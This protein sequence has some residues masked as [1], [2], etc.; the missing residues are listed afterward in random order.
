M[1]IFLSSKRAALRL[2]RLINPMAWVWATV[3]AAAII[4]AALFW[5][6]AR[7]RR[8][9][10]HFTREQVIVRQARQDLS[11]GYLHVTLAGR[12]GSPFDRGQGLAL[13]GQA[14][15]GL[16]R[17]LGLKHEFGDADEASHSQLALFRRAVED[18]RA[19][20]IGR[21]DVSAP[22]PASE[23]G[24]RIAFFELEQKANAVDVLIQQ[25]LSRMMRGY[26]RFHATVLW[27]SAV[28]LFFICLAVY[29]GDRARKLAEK[30]LRTNEEIY[31]LIVTN[32]SEAILFTNPDGSVYSVNPAACR[33]FGRSEEE[34]RRVGRAGIVDAADPRL[35]AALEER[36]RTGSFDGE[37]NMLRSDG[38]KFQAE[39]STAIFRDS[40]GSERTSMIIRDITE[41]KRADEAI[42]AS[43][44]EIHHRVKNNM[45]VI[46]SLFNLQAAHITNEECRSILKEGQ[47]RIRSMSLVHEKLYQSRDLS[48]IDFGGYIRSLASQLFHSYLDSPDRIRLETEFEEIPLDI[49]SAVPCGL[50]LNELISNALK[51]AFPE[52]RTGTIRIELRR[53]PAG[54]VVLRVADDGVGL[55][56]GFDVRGTGSF[57][58]QI[59]NL[60][61]DQLDAKL[62]V[63]GTRGT[64]FTMTF[65]EGKYPPRI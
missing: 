47:A 15:S 39:I 44:R 49:N 14:G 2:G 36:R 20:V 30:A 59:V 33:M 10:D 63:D 17:A 19:Q 32:S 52:G 16:E 1:N 62:D 43:L 21:G 24:L 8:V 64:A 57:G 28:L 46:S 40:L 56:E 22:D 34:I 37:L 4:S 6:Q 18:F 9:I 38:T 12:P 5:N 58:L 35:P 61:V 48:K 26:D 42:R 54:S 65:G 11:N 23:A 25:D 3:I 31:R 27:S 50:I 13:I 55:P 29:A 51:H 60:L 53:G 41:R 45:Q 7:Q